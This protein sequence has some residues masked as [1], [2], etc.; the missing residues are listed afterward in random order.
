M[1][2]VETGD[3][4]DDTPIFGSELL[5]DDF[6]TYGK[7]KTLENTDVAQQET[8]LK[9]ENIGQRSSKKM[10]KI[11]ADKDQELELPEIKVILTRL[12]NSKSKDGPEVRPMVSL[13]NSQTASMV[14]QECVI[15]KDT[16]TESYSEGDED[17]PVKN[18]DNQSAEETEC[19]FCLK[20]YSTQTGLDTHIKQKHE[21][22]RR[23]IK[24]CLCSK[25]CESSISLGDHLAK[26]HEN[27]PL[28]GKESFPCAK[29]KFVFSFKTH[30]MEHNQRN[31]VCKQMAENRT[32]SN[33]IKDS[34]LQSE[35]TYK[36]QK[37]GE[38]R[39][40]TI[41]D[42]LNNNDKP[43]TCEVCLKSFDRPYSFR[44]H[45][46]QHS[47]AKYFKCHVCLYEFNME[48]TM[49][50][51]WKLHDAK[52]YFCSKCFERYETR[53]R[54][55][56]HISISCKLTTEKPELRCSVCD[57]QTNSK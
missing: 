44:R 8:S 12:K 25:A 57:L 33:E 14:K 5:T 26:E 46:F 18:E 54:L 29:C 38:F 1:V 10:K 28:T 6:E 23:N 20:G 56:Y 51:H 27:Y 43:R 24:C 9:V 42:L 53:A 37:T 41:K 39:K 52:P 35:I 32:E 3:D 30:L 17:E 34:I 21:K 19:K 7:S 16:L 31:S 50:R 15:E 2:F 49:R 4:Y 40:K 11:K 13:L 36:D 55:D 22:N 48:E 47:A 45:I